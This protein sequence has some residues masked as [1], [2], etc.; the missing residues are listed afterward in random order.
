MTGQLELTLVSFKKNALIVIEGKSGADEFYIIQRGRVRIAK[1]AE[2]EVDEGG[3]TRGPGDFFAV[4]SAMS[5]HSHVETATALT[6]VTL[7]AIRRDQYGEFIQKHP[8]VAMKIILDFSR[9]LRRLDEALSRLALKKNAG[10]GISHLFVVGG[11]YAQQGHYPEAY[12]AYH[13]YLQ[14]CPRGEFASAAGE[15]MKEL[16]PRAGAVKLDRDPLEFSRAYPK[17]SMFF[18][19]GEPGDELYIIQKGAVKISKIVDNH[20]VLLAVLRGGDIFG[21]MA[22]LEQKPRAANAVAHEDCIVMV[23]NR[24]NFTKTIR[25]QPQIIARL[26]TLQADRLWF[27]YKQLASALISHPLGRMY[28]TLRIY[29]ERDRI[30][31]R[32]GQTHLFNFGPPELVS[33]AGLSPAE[34]RPHIAKL[35]ENKFISLVKNQ[36]F[37]LDVAEINRQA[38]YFRTMR[39]LEES[40][41]GRAVEPRLS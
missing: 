4:I 32:D 26:T 37:S 8:S 19:E 16:A 17:D 13:R 14:Y 20:E 21:E 18:A 24:A 38:N 6:D 10:G 40:R 11:Y 2:A 12:Y 25:E 39:K 28:D 41:Q 33:M 35:L 7:I 27:I 36:L 34:G 31:M 5:A 1:E 23:V 15:R 22:L 3:G 9:R 30:D 29:L